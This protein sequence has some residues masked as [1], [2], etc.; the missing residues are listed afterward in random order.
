VRIPTSIRRQGDL[1]ARSCA[2]AAAT[3]IGATRPA[4]A[5]TAVARDGI[6]LRLHPR[7]GDT[8]RT[9]L[10]QLTEITITRPGTSPRPMATTVTVLARTIVQ[11][12]H[13]ASTT[14]LTVVDSAD[15]RSSDSHVGAMAAQAERSLRGQQLVLELAEDGTVEIARDAR[16]LAVSRDVTEAMASM[17]AVF[18]HRS[19]AIGER[20]QREMPLVSSNPL[21]GAGANAH[22]RAEFRLDSLG[23]HGELAFVSMRGEIVP[24]GDR[25]GPDLSGRM[26]GEMQVDR[27]R[28]WM[29]DSRF[30]LVVVSLVAA[31]GAAATA[32]M[33]F[34][35]KVTQRLRTMDKW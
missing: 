10:E 8:L 32:P 26:T 33:R 6:V 22:V 29:T 30:T 16:G 27:R 13:Q 11:A 9:R 4:M 25:P 34:L 17:P 24:D 19:V 2:V 23:R 14:V 35:T 12:S 28:G 20:W 18:P 7:V 15:V 1:L 5:Q 21:G 3:L 31:P